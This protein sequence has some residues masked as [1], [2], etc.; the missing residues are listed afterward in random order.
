MRLT[1]RRY[2]NVCVYKEGR[3]KTIIKEGRSEGRKEGRKDRKVG[4]TGRSEA[5]LEERSEVRSEDTC[6]QR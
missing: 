3:A 6:M 2:V 5:R 4:R 1:R